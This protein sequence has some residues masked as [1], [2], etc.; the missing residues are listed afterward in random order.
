MSDEKVLLTLQQ[1]EELRG[2]AARNGTWHHFVAVLM[3]W[4]WVANSRIAEL[5]REN[6]ELRAAQTWR[7]IETA[8]KDG[9]R[10]L[11]WTTYTLGRMVVAKS[12][13]DIHGW[14]MPGIGGL[15]LTHWM[16]LPKAPDIE[17]TMYDHSRA[18]DSD[19]DA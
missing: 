17:T 2:H 13:G 5:E 3:Q 4:A 18:A 12:H 10:V 19:G 15:T 16:P 8:P 7:P 9:T 6:S 11:G 1:I 14:T